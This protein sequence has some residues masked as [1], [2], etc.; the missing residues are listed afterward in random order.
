MQLD[1][2]HDIQKVY[3]KTLDSMSRPGLISNINE[4]AGKLDVAIG[5]FRSTLVLALMLFDTEVKFK[6]YSERATEITK[7]INQ[8]TYA[9]E[10][11]AESADF[12]LILNDAK[13]DELEKALLLA[14]SGDLL[15][16]HQG[17]TILVEADFVS[18]DRDLILTGP[19][20]AEERS[21]KVKVSGNWVDIRSEKNIEYPLGIDLIFTD[22]DDNIICLPRTTQIVKQVVE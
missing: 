15:N 5:C 11:E 19:G 10:T 12:I 1:L 7:F 4:Q 2:V 20:I 22:R 17:A 13:T 9:K 6:V 8:L 18:N 14:Y 16:P 21:I 3:R